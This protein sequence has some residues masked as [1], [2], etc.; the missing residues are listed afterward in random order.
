MRNAFK[1]HLNKNMHGIGLEI[2]ES[3]RIFWEKLM[4]MAARVVKYYKF[5]VI[6]EYRALI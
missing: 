5:Y 2:C 4:V 1:Y 6:A 3:L